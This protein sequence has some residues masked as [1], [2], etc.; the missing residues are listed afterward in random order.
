MGGICGIVTFDGSSVPEASWQSMV[1]AAAHRG[2]DGVAHWSGAG[3][4]LVHQF[5]AVTGEE[6]P[7]AQAA[8]WHDLVCVADARIDNRPELVAELEPQTREQAPGPA[9]DAEL[10]L[11]AYRR[12]GSD[13]AEQ[14]VGDFSVVVWD[15]GRRVLLGARDPLGM[16][17]FAYRV[18]AGRRLLFA[19]EVKQIL[20]VDGT[21]V[22]IREEAVAADLVAH[23]GRPEWSFYEGI[24]LL[25]PGHVLECDVGGLRR[26]RYWD[27]DPNHRVQLQTAE[28]YAEE[29]RA[30]F[31][32]AVS[33]R[34][35]APVPVGF[36]LSGGLDSGSAASSAGWLAERGEIGAGPIHALSFAFE[37][38]PEADERHISR[39]IV[40]RY[41]FQGIEMPVD[42]KGPLSGFPSYLS[43]R[44]D[45]FLFSFQPAVETAVQRL[46]DA[47]ARI[48]LGGDRGDLLIGPVDA[49]PWALLRLRRWRDARLELTEHV[50]AGGQ[51]RWATARWELLAPLLATARR[52]TPVG[53]FRWARQR[54]GRG[55]P[56]DGVTAIP[57]GS[58]WLRPDFA[59][60]I[61]LAGILREPWHV[62]PGLTPARER[63]YEYVFNQMQLRGLS[64][65]ERIYARR[66]CRFADPFSDARLV[67][68][69]VAL[70]QGVI[71]SR[72]A[73][74]KPLLRAAM[75]GIIPEQAR[76]RARKIV[77]TPLYE[78]AVLRT[79]TPLV[80]ELLRSPLLAQAGWV[81][82]EALRRHYEA[83]LGGAELAAEFWWTLG[84]EVWL[85]AH[86]SG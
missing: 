61:G 25:E 11:A 68:L 15:A 3:A 10:L 55:S 1:A 80:R 71:N 59:E 23:F 76:Q 5:T 70:P 47:G 74:P 84:V 35:R 46:R 77:P 37:T 75:R 12:W 30:V 20:A 60:R 19:T 28:E 73:D 50:R 72:G 27:V 64:A 4:A 6:Q 63:R 51:S 32:R 41:G 31:V 57:G 79:A 78:R 48:V 34:L 36:L 29:L 82:P 33:D 14:V 16:R 2:A 24:D 8:V 66:G 17:L 45:P 54:R 85:R 56:A 86:H 52:R 44:D 58:G 13:W 62:P 53:W 81:D 69:A 49:T 42:D 83:A 9:T 40:D 21:P 67:R 22:R 7:R 39:L 18:E 65:S 38:L 26:R 43:D